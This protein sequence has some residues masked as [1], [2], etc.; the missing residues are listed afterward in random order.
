MLMLPG[1]IGIA[2]ERAKDSG[3]GDDGPRE[4]EK[5]KKRKG[6]KKR[7]S[8]AVDDA[9]GQEWGFADVG[10]AG[11]NEPEYSDDE[12]FQQMDQDWENDYEPSGNGSGHGG[13]GGG[14]K[15]FQGYPAVN[16][17]SGGG[18]GN[19]KAKPK[20]GIPPIDSGRNKVRY[21]IIHWGWI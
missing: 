4:E 13:G 11:Y 17:A 21:H 14:G 20:S 9:P 1:G 16:G 15:D 5:K 18:K 7:R 2:G 10:G 3:G 8:K 12:D 19:S 6:K